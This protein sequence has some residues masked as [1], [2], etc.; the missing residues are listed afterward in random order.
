MA[1]VTPPAGPVKP[2]SVGPP[3]PGVA[4]RILDE[5]GRELPRGQVGEVAVHGPN[6]MLGYLN[7][8]EETAQ[9]LRDGW[10]R[11][12]DL[13]YVDEDGYVFLVDRKK[14][15]ILVGGM[16]VYP[17]EVEEVLLT[18]PAV[19]QAAVVGRM[20]PLRGETVRAVVVLRP[21]QTA[22]A[23]E[24]GAF[25][26]RHLAAFKCPREVEFRE[27]LP[28]LPTGKVDRKALRQT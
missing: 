23:G 7:R 22:T 3:L 14:D 1:Y 4:V 16:N 12:G 19:A 25:C 26:R 24:L 28:L 5:A 27:E 17:R 9:V 2:G 15:L 21:G 8:P 11:T 20:H 18:H 6:V 13:G 10:L